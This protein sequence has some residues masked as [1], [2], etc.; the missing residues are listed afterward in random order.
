M[1]NSHAFDSYKNIEGK[2][3]LNDNVLI[4][5]LFFFSMNPT[6]HTVCKAPPLFKMSPQAFICGLEAQTSNEQL[7]KLFRLAWNLHNGESKTLAS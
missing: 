3:E 4:F 2:T 1:H 6:H 7:A 5:F